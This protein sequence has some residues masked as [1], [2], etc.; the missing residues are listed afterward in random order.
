MKGYIY[1]LTNIKTKDFY[2]G[3]IIKDPHHRFVEH[4]LS[5]YTKFNQTSSIVLFEQTSIHDVTVK[6]LMTVFVNDIK[7]LRDI[8]MMFI[9]SNIHC[10][11]KSGKT[12]INKFEKQ[13]KQNYFSKI[14]CEKLGMTDINQSGLNISR[15][16]IGKVIDWIPKYRKKLNYYFD[17]RDR[18]KSQKLNIKDCVNYLNQIFKNVS[19]I[20]IVAGKRIRQR[21]NGK[22]V[23]I[24][25]FITKPRNQNEE[26]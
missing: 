18:Y 13:E 4:Q 23:T 19:F 25:G 21:V 14:I 6:T 24:S 10:V 5:Y 2:I 7:K 16:E 20:K 15:D 12:K 8:E 17:I 26:D 9:K 1:K 22:Q 11:N 3:S